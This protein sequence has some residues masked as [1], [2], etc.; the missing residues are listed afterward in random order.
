MKAQSR[1][2][3]ILLA[4][5]M[6]FGCPGRADI[7]EEPY[8]TFG[9]IEVGERLVWSLTPTQTLLVLDPEPGS[10]VGVRRL[11]FEPVALQ[12][13][14]DRVLA[15]GVASEG[16]QLVVAG[17]VDDSVDRIGLSTSFNRIVVSATGEVA[18]LLFDPDKAP[19]SGGPAVRNANEIAIVDIGKREATRVLL[20]TESLAPRSVHF[21]PDGKLCAVTLDSAVVIVDLQDTSRR[22]QVPLVLQGGVRLRPQEVLFSADSAHLFM[23]VSGTADVVSLTID[24]S[25]SELTGHINF[26]FASGAQR[27][28]DILV[29]KGP[30]FEGL[31]AAVFSTEGSGSIAALLDASGDRSRT[32][33]VQL[34]TGASRIEDL[35]EGMLLLYGDDTLVGWLA[36]ED[37]V[38][39]DRLAGSTRGGP[40]VVG[41][42]ALFSHGSP[43]SEHALSVVSVRTETTRIRVSQRLLVLS[44]P[45]QDIRPDPASE[46]VLLA[47]KVP[48]EDSGAA[49]DY[50]GRTSG[51]T[52]SL[53]L[54]STADGTIRD[55]VLDEVID[56]VGAVGSYYYVVHP[57]DFGDITFIPKAEAQRTSAHRRDGFLLTGLLDLSG[58]D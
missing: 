30:G 26:L 31:V 45:A 43:E 16:P 18:V 57:G 10:V 54:L 46:M 7:Y 48:R 56:R 28:L 39:E 23:Q 1:S 53:V 25:S 49:P 35:G 41:A 34:Q 11:G 12:A 52:G 24:N 29:P 58:E 40:S 21:S 44:G 4:V 5:S 36:F 55:V 32:R 8:A 22:L 51:D 9:P 6:V 17:T 42:V 50:E 20:D 37:R 47:V 15:L 27:L 33:A 3:G 19:Q 14:G 13:A 2:V 38:D